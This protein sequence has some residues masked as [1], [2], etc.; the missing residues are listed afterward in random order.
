ML[1]NNL[2]LLLTN[3]LMPC[4]TLHNPKL[5]IKKIC[6]LTSSN[7]IKSHQQLTPLKQLTNKWLNKLTLPQLPQKTKMFSRSKSQSLQLFRVLKWPSPHQLLMLLSSRPRPRPCLKKHLPHHQNILKLLSSLYNIL[8]LLLLRIIIAKISSSEHPSRAKQMIS[9]TTTCRWITSQLM[10]FQ[11]SSRQALCKKNHLC[12]IKHQKHHFK[13]I[14]KST[15]NRATHQSKFPSA[16]PST[17][18][19]PRHPATNPNKD[20]AN[21]SNN[22]SRMKFNKE[23][24]LKKSR[25]V[26]G[27]QAV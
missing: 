12:K 26:Y 3:S 24:E 10:A 9:K 18:A 23:T 21:N 22:R 6:R 16:R 13:I 20:Q 11:S 4:L 8:M 19:R 15:E 25:E 27:A 2:R 17:H 14:R 5:L 1:R 7:L